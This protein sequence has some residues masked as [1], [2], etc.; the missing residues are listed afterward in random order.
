MK[1]VHDLTRC[2]HCWP[3]THPIPRTNRE[4]ENM[5]KSGRQSYPQKTYLKTGPQARLSMLIFSK[6]YPT[7][8][9]Y[10]AGS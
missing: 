9:I 1:P 2:C 3:G 10:L 8:R 4:E 7:I 5:A 6:V